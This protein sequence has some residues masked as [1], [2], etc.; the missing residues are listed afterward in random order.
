MCTINH[1]GLKFPHNKSCIHSAVGR[2][3]GSEESI[4]SP[5]GSKTSGKTSSKLEII[6][7]HDQIMNT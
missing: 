2:A 5:P 7:T 4:R 6:N 3:M 1:S